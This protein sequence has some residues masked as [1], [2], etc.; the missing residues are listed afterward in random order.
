MMVPA[1][2]RFDETTHDPQY[3]KAKWLP[4]PGFGGS[5]DVWIIA[6][7]LG[8]TRAFCIL[9]IDTAETGN[10]SLVWLPTAQLKITPLGDRS[11]EDG[12]EPPTY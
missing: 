10:Y 1:F 6:Y 11:N 3:V 9:H 5:I 12:N 8:A 2:D 7:S 4:P